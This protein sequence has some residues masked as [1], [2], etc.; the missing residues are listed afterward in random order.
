M[1]DVECKISYDN[2]VVHFL[3]VKLKY[4]RRFRFL[5]LTI[6]SCSIF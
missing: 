5:K 6:R 2:R 4:F 3:I 1:K